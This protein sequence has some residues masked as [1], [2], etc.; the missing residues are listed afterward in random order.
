MHYVCGVIDKLFDI[1]KINV[2]VDKSRE[3]IRTIPTYMVGND[4]SSLTISHVS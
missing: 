1:K 2:F 3:Y 4:E